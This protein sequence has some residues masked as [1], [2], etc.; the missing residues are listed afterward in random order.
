M[1][2]PKRSEDRN[3]TPTPQ[4]PDGDLHEEAVPPPGL[5]PGQKTDRDSTVLDELEIG[6]DEP[7]ID[8]NEEQQ[9]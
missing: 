2:D 1:A 4:R 6:R 9:R 7:K 5:K 8:L 3:Y